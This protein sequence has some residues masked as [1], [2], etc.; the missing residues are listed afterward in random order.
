MTSWRHFGSPVFGDDADRDAPVVVVH[1]PTS[2]FLTS[3]LSL[4]ERAG[5]VTFDDA[6]SAARFL[7]RHASEPCFSLVAADSTSDLDA[8]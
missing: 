7:A 1:E 2:L 6:E 8:A 4:G 3:G 5:A